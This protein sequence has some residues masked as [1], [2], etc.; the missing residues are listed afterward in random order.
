[1]PGLIVEPRLPSEMPLE[2]PLGTSSK[3]KLRAGT[4]AGELFGITIRPPAEIGVRYPLAPATPPPAAGVGMDFSYAPEQPVMLL[5][6]PDA[7]RVELA[8]ASVG[9]AL[10]VSGAKASFGLNADLQGLRIVIKPREGDNFLRTVVGEAPAAIDVPLGIEWS[11]TTG[12][13]FKGSAAFEI[14]LHPHL[15]LGPVRV[16]DAT[17]RLAAAADEPAL[18]L[19]VTADMTGRIG[20]IEFVLMGTGFKVETRFEPGNAGPFDARL[21]FKPP[22]GAGLAIDAGGFVGGGFLRFDV[23]K[24]EYSGGLELM[25][26]EKLATRAL[27]IITTRMP[28]DGDGFSLLLLIT[29]DIPPVR[30]PFGFVLE[31]V[32][33]LLALNRTSDREILRAGV[34]DGTLDSVL[35]P[36]DVV[37]NAPRILGDLQRVF[38]IKQGLFLVGPMALIT[39]GTPTFVTVKLGVIVEL[40]RVGLAVIGVLR[41]VLPTDDAAILRLQ[42]NFVGTVDF[43]SGQIQFDASLFDSRLLNFTLTGDMAVRVYWKKNANILLTVGGFNPAYTP[44]PMNL[45]AL[46]RLSIILFDGNPDV[47]AEGYFAITSN[48]LQ[49]G[50]RLEL[51]YR[52]SPFS[53]AG[54][55]ALDVLMTRSP[56]YFVAEVAG[57]VAVRA[58]GS[59][60]FSIRLQLTLEGPTPWRA[61]GTGSF[62]IGFVFTVTIR[63]KFDVAFGDPISR[64]LQAVNVLD[65]LARAVGDIANWVPRLPSGSHQSVTMR[66]LPA[67]E[68]M[69]VLH[70]FGFLDISQ[71][72]VPLG[73][74]IQ[75]FGATVPNQGSVFKIVDVTLGDS[76]A[77]TEPRHEEFAPAQF[78]EMS[79]AEKLS[80][81]SF[82][83]LEAG[84]AIG[85]DPLPHSDW[86]RHREVAY[87]L[88][89]L[90][91]RH[92]VR[93]RFSMPAELAGFS[94]AGAAAAR[95]RLSHSTTSASVLSERVTFEEDRY[96]VVST[97]NLALHS[98]D[99]VFDSATAAQAA[100]RRLVGS[101]PELTGA[102]QV[103]PTAALQPAEVP[104]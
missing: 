59:S 5:G 64:L 29:S 44:P 37:A 48:T 23:E 92:P 47:R 51:A 61:R 13:R 100:L 75:R 19:Q 95:S 86:L 57:M 11:E 69:L 24:E 63:V 87:E 45:P 31:G 82:E 4:N 49:F 102:L 32:G 28:D 43:E 46:R 41:A 80:R 76:M 101:R 65:E 55:V 99:F 98:D 84:I 97:E 96:A 1:M 54:F 77:Q 88:I 3:M 53:V 58:G 7:T 74:P 35:F 20:P 70:P 56:L 103:I 83:T 16:D 91:E 94:M 25:F 15:H 60:L 26:K 9:L 90:P 71:K 18:V 30:L 67:G 89:Y 40:P 8:S 93:P 78:F 12:V 27:A 6:D 66:A 36:T 104:G 33:G 79:D 2:F 10:G 38:P 17:V 62:E 22:D 81:P 42:V 14:T 34:R 50:A 21:G 72:V 85:G 68:K 52:F 73:L 39:W